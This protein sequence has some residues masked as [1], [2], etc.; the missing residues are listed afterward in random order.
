MKNLLKILG[1]ALDIES[2]SDGRNKIDFDSH[3][4]V[5]GLPAYYQTCNPYGMFPVDVIETG[6]KNIYIY[7]II[8]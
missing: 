2:Y 3:S 4:T 6:F 5:F 1:W 7:R 8:L